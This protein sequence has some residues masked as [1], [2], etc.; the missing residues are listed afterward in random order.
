M[1]PTFA[2]WRLVWGAWLLATALGCGSGDAKSE[3]ELL[4][5]EGEALFY[6]ALAGEKELRGPAIDALEEGMRLEPEHGRGSLMY[7]MALLSALA[8]DLNFLVLGQVEP[9]FER[10]IVLNPDDARI[11]GWLGTVQ[12][13]TATV[14]G[15]EA[16]LEQ[17]I[18]A[19]IE[20]ADAYPE[21]NNFSLALA[22]A[23]LPL[24]TPYPQMALDRLLSI[25]DCADTHDVCQNTPLVP[26]NVEGS[27]MTIGDVYARLGHLDE[28]RAHYEAALATSDSARWAHRATAELYLANIE[29]RVANMATDEPSEPPPWFSEGPT[30]CVGCHGRSVQ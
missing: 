25:L 10:A 20:A 22:F 17:A 14:L 1:R 7:A 16:E 5:E 23:R 21:F 3:G 6:R 29:D 4:L 8:E 13:R 24:S 19:M 30:S 12:V 2:T 15:N 11:P 27:L 28:A 9:A 18:A 26:H